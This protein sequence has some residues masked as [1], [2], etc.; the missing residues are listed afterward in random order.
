LPFIHF[1]KANEQESACLT[2]QSD[3]YVSAATLAGWG[4]KEV[5]LTLGSKGSLIYAEG[6]YHE[7]PAFLP[8]TIKDAT[9]CGDTYMAGYLSQRRKGQSIS[10]AGI[11]AAAMATLKIQ[12]SGPFEGDRKAIE[13][14]IQRGSRYYQPNR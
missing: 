13:Q 9:G 2:G 6:K 5:I 1:L 14:V 11:Y 12:T 8:D 4:V 10:E 7:I 3:P